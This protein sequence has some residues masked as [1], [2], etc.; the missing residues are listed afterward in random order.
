MYMF[1]NRRT[2][3]IGECIRNRSLRATYRDMAFTRPA[4]ATVDSLRKQN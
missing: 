2:S 3:N 1:L 4:V